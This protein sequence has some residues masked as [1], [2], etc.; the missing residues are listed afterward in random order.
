MEET[1]FSYGGYLIFHRE[2]IIKEN[3]KVSDNIDRFNEAIWTKV[4]DSVQYVSGSRQVAVE[5]DKF[6]LRGIKF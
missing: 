3:T 1:G 5:P 2:S 4:E 6:C